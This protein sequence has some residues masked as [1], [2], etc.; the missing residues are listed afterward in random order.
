G[1]G[2]LVVADHPA[3]KDVREEGEG[4][5]VIASTYDLGA[6]KLDAIR[7]S[8]D[9]WRSENYPSSEPVS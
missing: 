6:A 4:S 3:I 1:E 7:S 5:L 8:W 9:S 2:L